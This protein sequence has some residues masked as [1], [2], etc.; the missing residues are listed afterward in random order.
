MNNLLLSEIILHHF[1]QSPV[2][3]YSDYPFRKIIRKYGCRGLIF[4]EMVSGKGYLMNP[5]F[6]EEILHFD[7]SDR[8]VGIQ[9]FGGDPEAIAL[10]AEAIEKKFHPDLIDINMGCPARK[11]THKLGGAGLLNNPHLAEKI[12]RECVK[13]VKTPVSIKTRIGWNYGDMLSRTL[14]KS[15]EENGLI[16]VFLH[17]RPKTGLFSGKLELEN[18]LSIKK[19]FKI[20]LIANGGV[21]SKDDF[22]RIYGNIKDCGVMIGRG[23][24]GNPWLFKIKEPDYSTPS[25]SERLSVLKEHLCLTV[26]Y[27]GEEHGIPK[28]R[29]FYKPYL[30]GISNH[31]KFLPS[32]FREKNLSDI[33]NIINLFAV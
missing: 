6:H 17:L 12:I 26:N 7:D 28:F 22:L 4:T 31:T 16:C 5:S 15:A 24:F 33:L 18:F 14:I 10:A 30:T 2:A 8:P 32:L 11:V 9:I 23:S 1:S 19:E 29:K 13:R 20:P 21:Y 3:G 27:F 25:I